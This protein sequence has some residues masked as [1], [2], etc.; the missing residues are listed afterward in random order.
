MSE[1]EGGDERIEEIYKLLKKN[2]RM[3]KRM[4]EAQRR[5][6]FLRI[7]QWV[8][9]IFL[10]VLV[11]IYIEPYIV[12]L[13]SLYDVIQ[14]ASAGAQNIVDQLSEYGNGTE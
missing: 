6:A 3:V 5:A 4:Y 7:L 10:A 14:G 1:Y 9:I 11:Y 13:E 12:Q 2:N 8:V